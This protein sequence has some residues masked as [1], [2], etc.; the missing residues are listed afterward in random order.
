MTRETGRIMTVAARSGRLGYALVIDGRLTHWGT[1]EK[2]AASPSS[3]AAMLRTWVARYAPDILVSERPD[4]S[5]RKGAKQRAILRVFASLGEDLPLL[6]I[7]IARR[8]RYANIYAE[9]EA[10]G[11]QFP[12]LATKVPKKP[13]IWE[14]EPYRLVYFEALALLFDA[15]LI[16][17]DDRE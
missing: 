15:G 5:S 16:A 7:V 17:E 9:A 12:E 8:H 4:V 3:A 14:S 13:P 6:N 2:G 10:V 1:S 11:L